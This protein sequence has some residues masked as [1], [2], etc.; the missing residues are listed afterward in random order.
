M[1]EKP[2]GSFHLSWPMYSVPPCSR[3]CR[4][5]V[6][7]D[8]PLVAPPKRHAKQQI[9]SLLS[10]PITRLC[11]LLASSHVPRAQPR[12]RIRAMPSAVRESLEVDA[13]LTGV[14]KILR[15]LLHERVHAASHGRDRH[16]YTP[17]RQLHLLLLLLWHGAILGQ[18]LQGS[19]GCELRIAVQSQNG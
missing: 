4:I 14:T 11:S 5:H 9:L 19:L 12:K 18:A 1:S 7:C 6:F 3:Y 16:R 2:V 8:K 13:F 10:P 17:L 15:L